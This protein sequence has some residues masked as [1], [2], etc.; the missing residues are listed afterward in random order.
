MI[1]RSFRNPVDNISH[2]VLRQQKRPSLDVF[3]TT[4]KDESPC[5]LTRNTGSLPLECTSSQ[6]CVVILVNDIQI[7]VEWGLGFPRYQV[8]SQIVILF[9]IFF[10]L[11]PCNSGQVSKI[12]DYLCQ[13]KSFYVLGHCIQ[14]VLP[15]LFIT[16]ICSF[17]GFSLTRRL[18]KWQ[19]TKHLDLPQSSRSSTLFTDHLA[20]LGIGSFRCTRHM[21][22]SSNIRNGFVCP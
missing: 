17:F 2:S 9:S 15:E 20:C 1:K 16:L 7:Q 13:D 5:I 19:P 12:V 4:H 22:L 18:R 8:V 3:Q 14:I 21:H 6:N 10:C 11:C